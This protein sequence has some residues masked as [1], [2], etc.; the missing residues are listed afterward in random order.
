MPTSMCLYS[1]FS[2]RPF[3]DYLLAD[4]L[5]NL[6]HSSVSIHSPT[7]K[8][9][10]ADPRKQSLFA[11]GAQLR[12]ADLVDSVQQLSWHSCTIT[13]TL[14]NITS[15]KRFVLHLFSFS[16]EKTQLVFWRT[17]HPIMRSDAHHPKSFPMMLFLP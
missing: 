4:L 11:K 12:F 5:T 2:T 17:R 10:G 1:T 16:T 13:S 9:T 6:S 3:T 15:I 7:L 8:T 14:G